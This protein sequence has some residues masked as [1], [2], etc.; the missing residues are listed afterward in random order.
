MSK[1]GMA[2]TDRSTRRAG[3]QSEQAH[4]QGIVKSEM[5]PSSD[6]WGLFSSVE[7]SRTGPALPLLIFLFL[8]CDLEK[9]I[10]KRQ[11][12]QPKFLPLQVSPS[13]ESGGG[14]G[15]TDSVG[16]NGPGD[17][18]RPLAGST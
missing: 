6:G 2:R 4:I 12:P 3:W 5:D 9:R 15:V 10:S 14:S 11:D 18:P 1:A 8:S 17:D 16:A 7:E 13:V